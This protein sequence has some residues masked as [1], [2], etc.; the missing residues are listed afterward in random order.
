[1]DLTEDAGREAD[2]LRIPMDLQNR[3]N[4]IPPPAISHTHSQSNPFIFKP[5]FKVWVQ[6]ICHILNFLEL[7]V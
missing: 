6:F 1:M 4:G 7:R 2:F 3:L 5:L